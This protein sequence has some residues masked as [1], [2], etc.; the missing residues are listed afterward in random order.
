[1]VILLILGTTACGRRQEDTIISST[2]SNAQILD[3]VE[4]AHSWFH[5]K[6]IRPI[7]ARRLE[8]DE[9]VKTLE[10]S[11][12]VP[13]G[14]YLCR[15]EAGD[16]WPQTEKKL[17]ET[18]Q[19]TDEVDPEGWR[20]YLPRPDSQGVMAAQVPHAFTVHAKWGVLSGKAGD[21]IVKSFADRDVPYPDDVWI[22]DQ[23]LFAATYKAGGSER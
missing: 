22:V 6:K 1:L 21:F 15:G 14:H 16:I 19:K 8:K 5:A 13:A 10:G 12:Q 3:E 18:Y 2:S 4:R 17:D 7:W 20:K 11:E 23:K 9:A